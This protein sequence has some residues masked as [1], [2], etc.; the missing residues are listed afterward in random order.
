MSLG[1]LETLISEQEKLAS[2]ADPEQDER[3]EH[4]EVLDVRLRET[5]NQEQGRNKEFLRA[6]VYGVFLWSYERFPLKTEQNSS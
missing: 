4:A 5:H 2:A 1:E 3:P 6:L